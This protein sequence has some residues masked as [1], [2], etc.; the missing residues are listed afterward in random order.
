MCLLFFYI[1]SSLSFEDVQLLNLI[2]AGFLFIKAMKK[3]IFLLWL[4]VLVNTNLLA[5]NFN[6]LFHIDTCNTIVVS[7]K[8][9]KNNI[10]VAGYMNDLTV[11]QTG[12]QSFVAKFDLNGNK[13]SE[14]K[15]RNNKFWQVF[16]TANI[17]INSLNNELIVA[18]DAKDTTA[19]A[20]GS[21]FIQK[22]DTNLNLTYFI[23]ID[24][25]S[26]FSY[27]IPTGIINDNRDNLFVSGGIVNMNNFNGDPFLIKVNKFNQ[28]KSFSIFTQNPAKGDRGISMIKVNDTLEMIEQWSNRVYATDPDCREHFQNDLMKADTNCLLQSITPYV[29]SNATIASFIKLNNNYYGCGAEIILRHCDAG[30][31]FNYYR[32]SF[33]KFNN[34]YNLIFHQECAD[35][36]TDGFY[37]IKLVPQDKNL[38][39]VGINSTYGNP[40]TVGNINGAIA[41]YDTIGNLIWEHEYRGYTDTTR[42]GGGYDE[43]NDLLDFEFLADG[44]IIACGNIKRSE[45]NQLTGE[46]WLLRLS[47]D[48]CFSPT[49]CG[50]E[51][52]INDIK[53]ASNSRLNIIIFP[54]PSNDDIAVAIDDANAT[55]PMQ[56]VLFDMLGSKLKTIILTENNQTISTKELAQGNYVAV[57]SINNKVVGVNKFTHIH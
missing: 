15:I 4:L 51:S 14:V 49:D 40:A 26:N 29:D 43:S 10:Y 6:K 55:Y 5:Q 47:P 38:M 8:L 7:M 42:Q 16:I 24:T 3:L 9:L 30:G 19:N 39:M 32:P 48:G 28:L 13:I 53:N 23:K 52:G 56:M 44:S 2:G 22:M 33:Y 11:Y 17:E 46:G 18:G 57:F 27:F 37:K 31:G 12:I 45:P 25:S 54:N 50:V 41:K 35:T 34:N 36:F 20:K 1:F 21:L